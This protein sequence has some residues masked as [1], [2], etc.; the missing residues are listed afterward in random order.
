MFVVAL[1]D[2]EKG[3]I[4]IPPE[5]IRSHYFSDYS[6]ADS[7]CHGL[8]YFNNGSSSGF[9]VAVPAGFMAYLFDEFID[10]DHCDEDGVL[11]I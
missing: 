4:S 11:I 9:F 6:S 1:L 2:K 5:S 10:F 7:F 8:N 3:K